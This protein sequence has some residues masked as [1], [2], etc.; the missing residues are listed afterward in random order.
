MFQLRNN[1]LSPEESRK[2]I[3]MSKISIRHYYNF[4]AS[5]GQGKNNS[6]EQNAHSSLLLHDRKRDL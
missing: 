2:N 4:R 3:A 6:N 1:F 5:K